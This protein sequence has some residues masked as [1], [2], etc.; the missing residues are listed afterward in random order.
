MFEGPLQ[1]LQN[2]FIRRRMEQPVRFFGGG[3]RSRERLAPAAFTACLLRQRVR[4][5]K[6]PAA[7]TSLSSRC[8]TTSSR[9]TMRTT[10]G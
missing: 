7:E 4:S 1:Y 3:I 9:S 8:S 2:D 10:A 5:R 6:Q